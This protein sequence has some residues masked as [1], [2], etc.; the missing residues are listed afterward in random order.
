M[1]LHIE[2][3]TRFLKVYHLVPG[4]LAIATPIS[5]GLSWPLKL[6]HQ[7]PPFWGV[8][9]CCLPP[10]TTFHCDPEVVWTL[11]CLFAWIFGQVGQGCLEMGLGNCGNSN[12]NKGPKKDLKHYWNDPKNGLFLRNIP[13]MTFNK[14]MEQLVNGWLVDSLRLLLVDSSRWQKDICH[15]FVTIDRNDDIRSQ[16]RL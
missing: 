13:K 6:R 10:S 4:S 14:I 2:S 3:G 7:A 8:E 5:L 12:K 15:S 16:V 9:A 11:S 1:S